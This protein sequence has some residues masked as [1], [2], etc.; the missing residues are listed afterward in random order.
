MKS[1]KMVSLFMLVT[2]IAVSCSK[3]DTTAPVI[4]IT[5]PVNGQIVK[6]NTNFNVSG[7]ITDDTELKEIIVAGNSITAFTSKT[8][9]TVNISLNVGN[10]PVG[11][12]NIEISATDKAGNKASKTITLKVE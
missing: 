4:N 2:F 10:T 9:H 12:V 5:S 1:L 3:D 6:Q 7:T 11:D 8:S